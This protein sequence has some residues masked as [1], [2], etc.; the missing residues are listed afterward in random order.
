MKRLPD[1]VRAYR[2]TASFTE[3]TI[4]AGL[5]SDHHTKPGVWAK[6]HIERGELLYTVK[7]KK[8]LLRPGLP[9]IIEPEVPHF[10]TPQG[11]VAFFVEFYKAP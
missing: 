8:H 4:P 11:A 9:G 7:D 10:V 3:E 1:N 5:L 2:R 6:I